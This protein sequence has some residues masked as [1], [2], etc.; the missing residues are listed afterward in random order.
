M[1]EHKI[2]DY[3]SH[4]RAIRTAIAGLA[5]AVLASGWMIAIENS[6]GIVLWIFGLIVVGY[7]FV[8]TLVDS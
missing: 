2:T 7:S 1:G 4:L 6:F 3:E 5:I 8:P